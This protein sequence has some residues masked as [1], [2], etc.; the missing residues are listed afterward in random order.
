M[1]KR[2]MRNELAALSFSEKVD[3]LE[4]LRDRSLALAAAGPRRE[5]ER[6]E[7]PR[8]RRVYCEH[9]ALTKEI[10]R[11]AQGGSIE[12]VHFP[13]DPDSHTP[14]MKVSTPSGARWCDLNLPIAELPGRWADYTESCRFPEILSIL[15]GTNRRDALHVDSAFKQGCVAFV[16]WDRDILDRKTELEGVVRMRFFR[17]DEHRSLAQFLVESGKTTK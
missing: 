15:G 5:V 6:K 3:I 8:L 13:Y 16:T 11:L 1:S 9:G 14:K 10:R 7:L 2:E 4:K 12:L 17:P